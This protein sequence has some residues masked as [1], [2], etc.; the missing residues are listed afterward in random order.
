MRS[1]SQENTN[2]NREDD[3]F[4]AKTGSVYDHQERG[5][6]L[7]YHARRSSQTTSRST[8]RQVSVGHAI[9]LSNIRT[10]MLVAVFMLILAALAAYITSRSWQNLQERVRE[11]ARQ[12]QPDPP[13]QPRTEP[14]TPTGIL[15]DALPGGAGPQVR[16]E[17]DMDAMRRAVL[18]QTRAETLMEAGNTAEAIERFQ[19]ALDIW[20]HLTTVWA[21]LGQA[22]LKDRQYNRAQF[23]LERAAESDPSN[24][25]VLNDLGV[26]LL[27]QNRLREA[28]KLFETVAETDPNH[29]ESHFNRALCHLSRDNKI[30]AEE[31]LNAYLQL[32]PDDPRALKEKAYLQASRKDY[33]S[34][35]ESLR[36]AL[37]VEPNWA[38]LHVD[39]AATAAL[40]GQPEKAIQFLKSAE[41]L[42]SPDVVH[43][44]FQ[45]PAFREI[46][47][48]ETGQQ[49][50]T[51]LNRRVQE[52]PAARQ[53]EESVST[54]APMTS[55][56][57][58]D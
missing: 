16:T 52:G 11:E 17:L 7:R 22:Y 45:Q 1:R 5:P 29:A 30:Q 56:R 50:E 40:I 49:Y 26:A 12:R 58:T 2:R 39:L 46:R 32:R 8:R 28:L 57:R 25:N 34:A 27:H 21:Q 20:P 42:T 10:F 43:R 4:P 53:D 15:V 9:L 36:R 18:M 3:A 37:A 44:I 19:T 54:T 35:L 48:S 33:E 41:T 14:E 31:A 47:I 6:R 38:P 24:P 51:A 23:A 55:D 13:P